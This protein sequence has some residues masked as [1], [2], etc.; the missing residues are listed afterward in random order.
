MKH[1]L[2][3]LTLFVFL[4]LPAMDVFAQHPKLQSGPM[5][6][7]SEMR[8]A[9]VWVQTTEAA[10]V[11]MR[12]YPL[13]NAKNV[14]L[15]DPVKTEKQRAHTAV[16]VA[17]Q[18][19]PGTRYVYEILIDGEAVKLPYST[20]FQTQKI[21][22]W[23]GNP[24][25]FSFLT[26][27]CAYINEE[28]FDR[29]GRPYGGDYRIFENMATHKA[30]FMLWLGDN[31]YL[32]EPDW[33]SRTGILARWTH[34]RSTKELQPFLASTHHYAIWDDHDYG[35]NDSDRGFFNKNLTLEAFSYFFANPTVGVGDIEGAITSF[36]WGD[37]DFFLLDNRWYRDPD[38]LIAE[39]KSI[40]G[41]K[42][43]Q[44]LLDNLVSSLATFKI[45]AMGG[46]FLS[47]ARMF[48]TYINNGFEAERQKIIDFIHQ[49]NI[50]NVVFVTG[51]VHFTEM[52]KLEMEGKPTIYDLTFST[53]TAGVN[54]RGGEWNNTLRVPGTVV[55]KRNFG[56]VS[57]RGENRNREL[58]VECYDTDNQLQWQQIIKQE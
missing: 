13:D 30:D 57:F 52:S 56:K 28:E 6:G 53:M 15:S 51:D 10:T 7:Y 40:L 47:T 3:Q 49:H 58:V 45:V 2:H 23:R 50:K 1:L 27:S 32:R 21:W 42:Q 12:Y 26:G 54:A 41:E 37:A 46:Q 29:P 17:D 25:E 14:R 39:N 31:I 33:N 11:Q 36:Q 34:T 55:T 16:L 20:E 8:E 22:K 35:P 24:P 44:W 5:P 4:F 18:V 38:N 43:L 9:V 48:E 19:K